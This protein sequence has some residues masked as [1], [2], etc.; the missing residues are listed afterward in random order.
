MLRRADFSDLFEI[1]EKDRIYSKCKMKILN[2]MS[3]DTTYIAFFKFDE[4]LEKY[5][6]M[7]LKTNSKNRLLKSK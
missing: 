5:L 1:G 4:I 2:E 3:G 6:F 7:V